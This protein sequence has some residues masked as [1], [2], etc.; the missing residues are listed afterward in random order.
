MS[1]LA[2]LAKSLEKAIGA[3]DEAQEVVNWL[4]T[5]YP[6]FNKILGGDGLTTGIPFGRIIEMYGPSSSGK[7]AIATLLMI[8]AQR[9]GGVA[10]FMDHENTF[11]VGMAQA[12]GLNTAFPFWIY[13]RPDTWEESNTWAMQASETIRSSKAI[14]P[15][16][17][18][19]VVFDSVASMIPKS[20]FAKGIDE[21]T[22]NDTSALSR[23]TS[24]TLKSVNQ[25]TSKM[26]ATM[27]YLNQIRTK[28]GVVFGDPTTTPGGGAMEFYSSIRLSLG[29]T[30]VMEEEDGKKQMT[31]QIITVKTV[32]NKVS[33]PFQEVKLNMMFNESGGIEF[34]AVGTMVDYL[35]DNNLLEY[36]KPYITWGGKKYYKKAFIQYIKDNNL[37][38]ELFKLYKE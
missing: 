19:I 36:S 38:D 7:T 1:S 31:G 9:K 4:D 28:I 30:R 15:D 8:E 32:K 29:R 20:V 13:K 12:M 24:T 27:L 22:M 14:P 2:E 34:D 21:L 37:K 23:V 35:M 33:R 18:I 17:P 6:P 3:N 10:M 26:N 25:F 5:G 11:D 16:A